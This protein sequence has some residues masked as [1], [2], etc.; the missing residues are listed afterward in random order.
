MAATGAWNRAN[1]DLVVARVEEDVL[2]LNAPVVDNALG[3]GAEAAG[4][5]G[6]GG[7]GVEGDGDDASNASGGSSRTASE[8]DVS[9]ADSILTDDGESSDS[10]I[11]HIS[12]DPSTDNDDVKDDDND[13]IISEPS[14]SPRIVKVGVTRKVVDAIVDDQSAEADANAEVE[15]IDN[16]ANESVAWEEYETPARND[17]DEGDDEEDAGVSLRPSEREQL[18]FDTNL[19]GRLRTFGETGVADPMLIQMLTH[20]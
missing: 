7:E 11:S 3:V 12:T 20:G 9:E 13:S 18:R 5:D 16:R 8:I 14:S 10:T 4:N 1:M 15:S 2:E 6:D 19:M 17:G